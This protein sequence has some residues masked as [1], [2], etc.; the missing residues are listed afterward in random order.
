MTPSPIPAPHP[1]PVISPEI[2]DD[3]RVTFR[4]HA[5]HA[6]TVKVWGE[7][8][9]EHALSRDENGVWSVTLGPLSPDLYGY[10][11]DADGVKLLDPSNTRTKPERSAT[12][13]VLDV[14][15]EKDVPLDAVAGTPRGTL[16]LHDYDSKSLG[17]TRRLRVYTP[18]AYEA[19]ADARFPILYL[20]HG[21]GDNEA[22]WSEFGR[23]HVIL[24]NLIAAKKAAPMIVVM[25]DGHAL[26]DFSPAARAGNVA[27]FER[28]L[29]EDVM[30]GVENRY[31]V[32]ADRASRAIAGLSMGGNQALIVGL[33][34]RD[35][36]ASIGAMS[37]AIREPQATLA[38]FW[39]DPVSAKTPLH[40]L[41]IAVGR[42][43]FLLE[44]NRRFHAM[45]SEKNVPHEYHETE[46]A[47][48][49]T[50]WRR[51]LADF[52]PRLFTTGER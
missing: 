32:R 45:L 10:R 14:P 30:P 12:T 48:R 2:G 3:R 25:T 20:L 46:G 22:T 9:S 38:S 50:V 26:T 21:S 17:R 29:L 1:A 41:W 42:D 35:G 52:A 43:D 18:A 19:Q 40:L 24:D 33:N 13:S 23:A 16:H 11:F 34:H 8:G 44:E 15:G 27:A 7:W 37:S 47:H 51:Y 28:D 39:A 49:W 6:T 4:L 5:P 31:R 36:F